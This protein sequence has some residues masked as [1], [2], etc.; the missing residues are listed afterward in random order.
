MKGQCVSFSR[1]ARLLS[2][3]RPTVR[4]P[5]TRVKILLNDG[6]PEIKKEQSF[7]CS[8]FPGAPRRIRTSDIQIRSLALYPAEPWAHVF[9]QRLGPEEQRV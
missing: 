9:V 4:A 8:F 1:H 2:P 6:Q 5:V 3:L 7:Y